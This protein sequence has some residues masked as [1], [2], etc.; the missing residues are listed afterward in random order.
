MKRK[1]PE[2]EEEGEEERVSE[3][4]YYH[5]CM[6]LF[7]RRS[8]YVKKAVQDSE[9][10]FRQEGIPMPIFSEDKSRTEFDRERSG[11]PE[12]NQDFGGQKK[13]I[14]AGYENFFDYY[15]LLSATN[16]HFYEMVLDELPCHFYV[17]AEVHLDTN[18]NLYL[19]GTEQLFFEEVFAQ[20]IELG[21]IESAK[22]V[23]VV[24]LDSSSDRK[25]SKHY[26][27]KIE[28]K[29]FRNNY[30]CGAFMRRL[31]NRF[32]R[33]YG[34]PHENMFFFWSDKETE[35]QYDAHKHN[36]LF[37][38]DVC[39][40]TMRRQFRLYYSS[41]LSAPE[42]ILLREG[43]D[44]QEYLTNPVMNKQAFMDTLIQRV[45]P[46]SLILDCPEE[47]GSTPQ[48]SSHRRFFITGEEPG[49]K[50][51]RIGTYD[52]GERDP[53]RQPEVARRNS[54]PAVCAKMVPL[55]QEQL[56]DGGI[57]QQA[58]HFF[59][60]SRIVSISTSSK[61]CSLVD[62]GFHRNNHIYW[63]VD[64]KKRVHY[65]KC[66]SDRCNGKRTPPKLIT[67]PKYLREIDQY[68]LEESE[69]GGTSHDTQK[70]LQ[71]FSECANLFSFAD[72]PIDPSTVLPWTS[73]E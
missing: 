16:R 63:V 50:Q 9:M 15:R 39:V 48:S 25:F 1:E 10:P 72:Q 17:D 31:H 47:N 46:G 12:L 5:R 56:K 3:D 18:K 62:E 29:C 8:G 20:M 19:E 57:A 28:G 54:F 53:A 67:D 58:T 69:A 26:L 34:Q 40:Y 59:P 22:D 65:Q 32:L 11:K 66:K 42:R 73:S 13:F 21:Y 43:E 7:F 37:F 2:P 23:R 24:T 35:F 60:L 49:A 45:P 4:F 51:M 6:G 41:K 61:A 44:R 55:V 52:G 68:L 27:F 70:S 71:I 38:A 33:L 64:L 14:A 30:H 36:K